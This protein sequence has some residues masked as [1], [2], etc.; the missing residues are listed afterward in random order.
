MTGVAALFARILERKLRRLPEVDPRVVAAMMSVDRRAFVARAWAPLAF[1]DRPIAIGSG[2]TI[3]QPSMIAI[4]L[5]AAR[6]RPTDRVL[7]VGTGSGYGAAV[8]GKLA[9]D[10]VSIERLGELARSA[11]AL[12][13]RSGVQN[14]RV[15]NGDGS[16]GAPSFG[17]FDAIV[18]TAAAPHVP[19]RLV[20]MLA[21]GGRLLVPVGNR[22]RQ[23]LTRVIASHGGRS[24]ESLGACAFVPLVGEDAWPP[25]RAGVAKK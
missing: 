20:E 5:S 24:V 8:L 1:V 17:T 7:E 25:Q 21:E 16:L 10:V 6:I 2:Q 9:R 12:L 23:V 15:E 3:S 4:M 18:V 19:S 11:A 22:E 14:V 13:A